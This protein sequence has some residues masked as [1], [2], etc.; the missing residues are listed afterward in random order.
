[1]LN[2]KEVKWGNILKALAIVVGVLFLAVFI[3]LVGVSFRSI[4]AGSAAK[5]MATNGVAGINGN[6][7][8]A[9][10]YD[11]KTLGLSARNIKNSGIMPPGT[12]GTSGDTAENYEIK[13]YAAQVETRNLQ[14]ECSKI[15]DLKKL[16][17]VIFENSTTGDRDC[18]FSFKVKKEKTAEI[19]ALL[20]SLDP[21]KFDG[22]FLY[23]A[24]PS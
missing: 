1:M 2:I 20:K 4:F 14:N 21:K 11:S 10:S 24:K 17:Y 7:S 3:S 6:Y 12:P 15:S 16:D 8:E 23:C 9:Y 5:P 22:K 19:L 18:N 13:T